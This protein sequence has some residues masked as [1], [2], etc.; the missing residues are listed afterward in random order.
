MT[1]LVKS[2]YTDPAFQ[3]HGFVNHIDSTIFDAGVIPGTQTPLFESYKVM[4]VQN[5]QSISGAGGKPRNIAVFRKVLGALPNTGQ[6][7]LLQMWQEGVD[8]NDSSA[9][10]SITVTP[11]GTVHI[12]M[13]FGKTVAA[14]RVAYQSWE[15]AI[16][17]SQFAAPIVRPTPTPPPTPGQYHLLDAPAMSPQWNQRL[18]P[19]ETGVLVDIPTTFNI[20]SKTSYIVRVAA[21][22][23][24]ADVRLRCGSQTF[25]FTL[26]L[27]TQVARVQVHAQGF[28]PGPQVYVSAVNG[29]VQ[30]WLQIMGW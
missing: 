4:L 13:S 18:I 24:K 28:I 11:D 9:A 5:L 12:I 8:Y 6:W 17:R 27:N 25:P 30:A 7:Q 20:A 15:A 23:D 26:T 16:P 21:V 19:A 29:P 14:N 3:D 1:T 22:A 2:Q 10:G